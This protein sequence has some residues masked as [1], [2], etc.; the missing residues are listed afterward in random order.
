MGQ[1]LPP[2]GWAGAWGLAEVPMVRPIVSRKPEPGARREVR[3]G[4]QIVADGK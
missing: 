1:E 2:T 3:E 4:S